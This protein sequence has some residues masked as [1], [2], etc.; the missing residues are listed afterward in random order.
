MHPE[1]E[2]HL[3]RHAEAFAASKPLFETGCVQAADRIRDALA[4]GG[5][6]LICGNGGSAAD[7]Q[8]WAAELVN[9]YRVDRPAMAAIALTTDSSVLTSIGNDSHF[10][11]LFARQVEA[12]GQPGDV[13]VGITTSGRSPNIVAALTTARQMRMTTIGLLGGESQGR[14][15]AD[16]CDLALVIPSKA[17]PSIQEMHLICIHLICDLLEAA[18]AR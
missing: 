14:P 13:L 1:I 4:K 6:L 8:H 9:R 3:S 2:I 10:D 12:L 16:H 18:A 15:A 5:K 11:R 7:A 17:T